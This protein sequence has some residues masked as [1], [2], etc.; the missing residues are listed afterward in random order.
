MSPTK[1]LGVLYS[2]VAES[3][4]VDLTRFMGCRNSY[5]FSK[6]GLGEKV[7]LIEK[8]LII[9]GSFEIIGMSEFLSNQFFLWLMTDCDNGLLVLADMMDGEVIPYTKK[10]CK[11]ISWAT[12]KI[13]EP[14]FSVPFY[15]F[16]PSHLHQASS[17][18][19]N[20][21]LKLCGALRQS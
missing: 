12:K 10:F 13:R 4:K 9:Q 20:A 17:K 16:S 3:C 21:A 2:K 7:S 6:C 8:L 11:Y 19:R 5:L 18:D 1:M 15:S 14:M